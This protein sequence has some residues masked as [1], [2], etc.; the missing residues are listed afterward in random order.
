MNISK[1]VWWIIGI[2]VAALVVF[3][4]VR[5]RPEV[6][7][8]KAPAPTVVTGEAVTIG[9]ILPFA[10]DDAALGIPLQ[11]SIQMAVDEF[12]SA[13]G[14][15][16]RP[17]RVQYEDGKCDENEAA[18]AA[19]KLVGVNKVKYI[20]GGA[21]SGETLGFAPIANENKVIVIS[22]SETSPNITT[23]GGEYVFRLAPSGAMA[24]SV[25]AQYAAKDLGARRAAIISEQTDYAQGLR[26][27]F[28]KAFEDQGGKIVVD[29]TYQ[30]G[31]TDFRSQALKI[32]TANV[33]IVYLLP[34]TSA[35]GV[36]IA[37]QLKENGIEAAVLAAEVL[38]GRETVKN[39]AADLEG[40]VGFE[41]FFDEKSER[42]APFLAAY[43]TKYNEVP[44]FPLFMANA[45]SIVYLV[46]DLIEQNQMDTEKA[47]KSLS[48]L[49]GWAGGALADVDL[50]ENGD[51]IWKNYWV[52]QVFQG[53]LKDIKVFTA[54]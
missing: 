29:E 49:S 24:G 37:K 5:Q 43:Q 52:K 19:Q 15:G 54:E 6:V 53:E 17:L 41:A 34:Q 7:G 18:T 12:N 3:L 21:C 48:T 30:T 14:V 51:I 23:K 9:A 32:K 28:K 1:L 38:I 33:D 16:G 46:K 40:L 35:P 13:R 25:A 2:V 26:A 45:Y 47:Q 4:L 39:N 10:G 27:T 20:I 11:R 31:E 22:P 8:P 50:D 36:L 42:A 44:P